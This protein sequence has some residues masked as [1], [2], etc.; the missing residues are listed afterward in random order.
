[1]SSA[2]LL[3]TVKNR[4]DI[5]QEGLARKLTGYWISYP[6]DVQIVNADGKLEKRPMLF[7]P[8]DNPRSDTKKE[9]RNK[10]MQ[11]DKFNTPVSLIAQYLLDAGCNLDNYA[12][13][14]V[15]PKHADI[16]D[17]S[18]WENTHVK[19]LKPVE[20]AYNLDDEHYLMC[21]VGGN[22]QNGE[23]H[24]LSYLANVHYLLIR[25]REHG[26]QGWVCELKNNVVSDT[27]TV[28]MGYRKLEKG[29]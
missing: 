9:E 14:G 11:K 25:L 26:Y 21:L 7:M 17:S 28:I 6:Y 8:V 19:P 18:E 23:I 24:W 13:S 27:H 3:S 29:N 12:F 20:M 2:K 10:E 15:T 5:V 22:N 1:M 16:F 4:E